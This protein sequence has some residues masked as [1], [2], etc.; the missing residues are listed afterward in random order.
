M[1]LNDYWLA[2]TLRL[3]E[4]AAGPLE[5][6]S[7]LRRVRTQAH[8]FAQKILMRAG[9]L[10]RREKLDVLIRRWSTGARL[11]LVALFVMSLFAGVGTAAGALGDGTRPVNV[12]LAIT[13]MLGVHL[14][15]FLLWLASF[16]INSPSGGAWLGEL[17]LWLTRKLTRGPDAALAPRALVEVL[18]RN[19]SLRWILSGVSHLL[20]SAA[21]IGLL[22]TLLALLSARR[23]GFVWETTLLS[24][25]TFVALTHAIG[26]LPAQL[27]FSIPSGAIVRASDGLQTVPGSAQGLWSSWLI[28]SVVVY[29][30]LPRGVALGV[31]LY[32]AHRRLARVALDTGLPGYAEL[33]D[34][35]EPASEHAGIDAE[36]SPDFLA[37]PAIHDVQPFRSGQPALLGIELPPDTPWPP[38][39]MPANVANLGIIDT[40]VQRKRILDALQQR[41]PGHLLLVCDGRQTPDR[42]TLA[43]IAELSGIAAHTHIAVLNTTDLPAPEDTRSAAWLRRLAAAGFGPDQVHM[44]TQKISAWPPANM[45]DDRPADRAYVQP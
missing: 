19:R 32:V 42:G 40:R 11:A 30:L 25:D 21:L 3:R 14:L 10:G 45:P 5:D 4:A 33:R 41:P 44:G 2:E 28:G 20:W 15:T 34:R 12:L 31:C 8:G 6:A 9:L 26:W 27:G 7:E 23:Y 35:L 43:L 22:A 1:S 38:A 16:A 13:A 29:G 18:G 39:G 24:A 17:W 37:L 36:A